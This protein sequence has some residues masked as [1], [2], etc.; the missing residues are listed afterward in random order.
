MI[1]RTSPADAGGRPRRIGSS[2]RRPA[3]AQR[4]WRSRS[5]GGASA[6]GVSGRNPTRVVR[7]GRSGCTRSSPSQGSFQRTW[8]ESNDPD[9]DAKLDR[10]EHVI[11][12]A[13]DRVRAAGRSPT[14][15]ACWAP[16]SPAAREL[17]Q[18]PRTPVPRLLSVGDDLWGV[19][20]RRKSAANTKAAL[21]LHPRP[22]PRR[23]AGLCDLGQPVRRKGTDIRKWAKRNKVELCHPHRQLMGEPHRSALRAAAR[24][25][26]QQL[27]PPQPH[28]AHPRS[29]AHLRWRNA[30]K[31]SPELLAAQRRERAR[32]RADNTAGADPP[33]QP[34]DQSAQTFG[35]QH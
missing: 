10:I 14:G 21:R 3:P 22:A 32:T 33:K 35:T 20:R 25:R 24:V 28:R 13:P 2:S 23:R 27:R 34:H 8:K 18:A 15:G 17:R 29:A 16:R 31:R 26:A 6:R 9:R 12:K 5:R 7:V 30:N 19:V 1:H 4:S 11:D